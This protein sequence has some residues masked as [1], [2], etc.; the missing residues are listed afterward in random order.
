M[1]TSVV[2][3][4]HGGLSY[5]LVVN[6]EKRTGRN[7]IKINAD[8]ASLETLRKVAAAHAL[9]TGERIG[10]REIV[11]AALALYVRERY[12]ELAINSALSC[13]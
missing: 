11:S 9:R 1:V 7:R 12:P 2:L 10:Q 5:A 6:E 4:N 8:V 13:D 3:D